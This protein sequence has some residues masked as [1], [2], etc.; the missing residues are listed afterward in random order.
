MALLTFGRGNPKILK[1]DKAGTSYLTA[2]IHLAPGKNSGYEVCPYA[3]AGCR[4][5]CL[6][7]AGRGA[8]SNVKKARIDR[9]KLLF[10]NPSQFY[11]QLTDEVS[12]F[13]RKC[14]RLGKK[15]AI[16]LNGTSDVNW[17]KV[18]PQLFSDFRYVQF[19]D[20]TKDIN[21]V[22]R[23][24]LNYYLVYSA[25]ENTPLKVFDTLLFT[26]GV[27]VAVVFK[28]VPQKYIGY[29]VIDGDKSD[30][31]FLDPPGVVVGLKAKGKARKDTLGFVV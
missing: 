25:S 27:N 16:R 6:Y 30:L 24:P 17:V 26:K 5:A 14:K 19:Y 2:I 28:T 21:R 31:R 20:Y 22:G 9:T 13:V 10:E 15:P 11:I 12:R 29:T 23:L 18:F 1:S 4:A 8:C 7:T 3:S